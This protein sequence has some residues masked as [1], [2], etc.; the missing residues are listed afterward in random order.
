MSNKPTYQLDVYCFSCA[1]LAEALE[2]GRLTVSSESPNV[3]E[4]TGE[5]LCR[6]AERRACQITE[7]EE[8]VA[9]LAK[10]NCDTC[11]R[12]LPYSRDEVPEGV[13]WCAECAA[14]EG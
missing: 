10:G 13:M 8:L 11:G 6:L 1:E 4:I 5:E 9:E 12:P 3:V 2:A 14:K 7:L